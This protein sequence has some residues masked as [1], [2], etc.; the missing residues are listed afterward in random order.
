MKTKKAK[1]DAHSIDVRASGRIRKISRSKALKQ[2][3]FARHIGVK[4]QQ[5]QKYVSDHN[6]VSAGKLF[7]IAELLDIRADLI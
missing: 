4:F 7:M 5:I 2:K 3:D 6:R 1:N